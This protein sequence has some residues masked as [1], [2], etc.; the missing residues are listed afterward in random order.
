[1]NTDKEL[2][3]I[4]YKFIDAYDKGAWGGLQAE[5]KQAIQNLIN[6]ARIDETTLWY[7]E[8]GKGK[9]DIGDGS[10]EDYYE[11]RVRTLKGKP[12]E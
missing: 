4:L 11:Y 12:T 1:M 10:W 8:W 3:E 2:D 5:A 6:E 7:E 9:E